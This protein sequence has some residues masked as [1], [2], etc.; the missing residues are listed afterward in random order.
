MQVIDFI[1]FNAITS[2]LVKNPTMQSLFLAV[3]DPEGNVLSSTPWRRVCGRFHRENDRTAIKC[4]QSD[5][6]LA[7][8]LNSGENY[9]LYTC[10]NSLT[11]A[12]TPITLDGEHIGNL[13]AGQV[14]IQQPDMDYFARQAEEC[15][16]DR[17]AYLAAITEVPVVS[18]AE[19][20]RIMAFY[21]EL[22][23]LL[24]AM[25]KQAYQY[26]EL[27]DKLSRRTQELE[28]VNGELEAFSYSV[29]HDLRAPLRHIM[30]FI[31]LFNKKYAQSLDAQGLH[32]F[33]VIHS[34]AQN[35]SRLID[36]LLQF[37]RNG[38]AELMREIVDMN[39]LVAEL[40]ES[41]ENG[42]RGRN[43]RWDVGPLEP[44]RCDRAMLRLVWH[45]L[46]DNAVK[47]TGKTAEPRIEI[48]NLPDNGEAVYCIRDNGAGFD[49]RYAQKLFGVFQRMHAKD[50]FEGTGIGLANV[51]RIISRHGGRIWAESNP[52]RGA[53]FYFTVPGKGE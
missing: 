44:A 49:M 12:A 16:F 5:R 42:A 13:V 14:F 6:I 23:S 2:V 27:S 19:L 45:N 21:S 11:D 34:S 7:N 40:L 9:A 38:R 10:F 15:G 20:R 26:K 4:R 43:I 3:T 25:A 46:I 22:T 35:M 28:Y 48:C 29:S 37:S 33:D 36:E 8:R 30:G 51:K 24:G 31:E 39:E 32:Y 1:D 41:M 50:E 17:Q 47:F 52:G 18:E 53:S